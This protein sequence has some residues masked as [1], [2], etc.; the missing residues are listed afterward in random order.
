MKLSSWR[1]TRRVTESLSI[2]IKAFPARLR[3]VREVNEVRAGKVLMAL[4]ERSKL[5]T[6]AA[7]GSISCI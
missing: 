6:V 1:L 7:Y 5:V 3:V 2:E 4:K